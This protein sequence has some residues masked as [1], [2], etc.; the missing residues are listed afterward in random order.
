[1]LTPRDGPDPVKHRDKPKRL[2]SDEN[3]E[4]LKKCLYLKLLE[5]Y[6]KQFGSGKQTWIRKKGKICDVTKQH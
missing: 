6:V 2:K 1:M 4:M 5:D 3:A